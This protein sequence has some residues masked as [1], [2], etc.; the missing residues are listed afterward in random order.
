MSACAEGTL[1]D[2]SQGTVAMAGILVLEKGCTT[3]LVSDTDMSMAFK[4]SNWAFKAS[5]IAV[6]LE[7]CLCPPIFTFYASSFGHEPISWLGYLSA[8][9]TL[10]LC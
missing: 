6:F 8:F 9:P 1:A 2:T 5:K 4:E 10:P 3:Q 7:N